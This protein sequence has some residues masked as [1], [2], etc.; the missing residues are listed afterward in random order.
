MKPDAII[1]YNTGKCGIDKSDQMA[2]YSTCNRRGVKWCR[3]VFCELLTGI[4]MVNAFN[5]YAEHSKC[6]SNINVFRENVARSLLFEISENRKSLSTVKVI[7]LLKK[8]EEKTR[9]QCKQCYINLTG[10]MSRAEA[11]KKVR[12][13]RTF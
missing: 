1:A 9:K 4:S 13:V 11:R 3:K 2:S 8:S 12:K 7:H 10:E 5:I 6:K